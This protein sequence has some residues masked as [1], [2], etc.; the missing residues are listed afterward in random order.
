MAEPKFNMPDHTMMKLG[1]KPVKLDRRTL[2][3]AKYL[4][5]NLP[6]SPSVLAPPAF[7]DWGVMLNDQL[8]DCTCA[9]MAHLIQAWTAANGNTRTVSDADVLRAYQ[10][11]GGYVP[12]RPETDNGAYEIDVLNYW[13]TTGIAGHKIAAF[14]TLD[15]RSRE[16]IKVACWL[17]GGAYVGVSL[18]VS[19]QNQETWRLDI[20]GLDGDPTPWSWGGHCIV[21]VGYNEI[22]PICVTWGALKQLTWA[23]HDSY[24]EEQYACLSR[25]FVQ[26]TTAPNG[27]D[28]NTLQADLALVV[29]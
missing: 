14:A 17:F 12:G 3:L 16:H 27:F 2:K 6:Q 7:T 24:A 26:G 9:G 20:S 29:G 25:D 15:P 13:R 1:R 5:G 19:A 28:F 4:T 18:P 11:V 23:W 21:Y 22:G 10:V 8:G